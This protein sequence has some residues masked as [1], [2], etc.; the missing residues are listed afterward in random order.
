ML[1]ARCARRAFLRVHVLNRLNAPVRL[2]VKASL[3]GSEA[4][5]P[6]RRDLN[7]VRQDRQPTLTFGSRTHPGDWSKHAFAL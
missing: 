1:C 7:R 6:L 2:T 5:Q 3:S 4:E